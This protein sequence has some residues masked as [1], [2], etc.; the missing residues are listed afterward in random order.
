MNLSRF[1]KMSLSLLLVLSLAWS[2]KLYAGDPPPLPLGLEEE[3]PADTE[4]PALPEGLDEGRE[5]RPL[6]PAEKDAAQLPFAL[7]G[8]WEARF[9]MRTQSDPNEKETS[10]AEARLQLQLE[11]PIKQA[12]F[13][14]TS[15]LLYDPILSNQDEIRLEEGWGFIDLREASLLLR[16]MDFMD[17][18]I[19]RQILTWG[20]GDL[21]FINDLFPKDWNAFFVGRDT[22][23]L[24]AP[25]DALKASF[26]S[27]KI[28]LDIVYTPRFDADRF[29]DGRRL[30]FFNTS[31]GRRTGRDALIQTEARNRWFKDDEVALRLYQNIKGAELALYSYQGYWKSPG[32]FNPTSKLAT[33]PKLS[34]YGGSVRGPLE[35]GIAHLE[36]GFYDSEED[37]KGNNPLIRNSEFRALLGYEQEVLRDLTA[38][39]QYYLEQILDYDHYRRNLPSGTSATDEKRHVVTLRLTQFLMNQNLRLSLFIFYSPSDKDAYFRPKIHYKIDDSWSGEIG[40]NVFIGKED[41]TFFSQ[42]ELNNNVYAGLR[43]SF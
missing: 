32:G 28:N 42:F 21:I 6:D 13:K 19:G 16:P 41:H 35:K 3:I 5:T 20:T 11:Q 43:F 22:E 24:K 9:G 40:G 34:V 8:F 26:F 38:T 18:K 33:F 4:E 37:R 15:D 31:L 36:L 14:F 17:V 12:I 2:P 39:I 10:I 25:S 1:H 30:S 29:I 27:T 23:Y 7:S